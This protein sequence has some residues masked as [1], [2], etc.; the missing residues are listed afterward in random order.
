VKKTVVA[1]EPVTPSVEPILQ[2]PKSFDSYVRQIRLFQQRR[3]IPTS[4]IASMIHS[5]LYMVPMSW[6]SEN[7]NRYAKDAQREI[8]KLCTG[9]F[10]FDQIKVL[11]ADSSSQEYLVEKLSKYAKRVQ[12]DLLVVLSSNRAGLP[13]WLLGSFSETVALTADLPVLVFKPHTKESDFSNKVRILV[14]FDVAATYSKKEISWLIDLAKNTNAHVD[15]VYAKPNQSRIF[16]SL[17][18]PKKQKDAGLNLDV[19]TSDFRKEG[20]SAS[21]KVLKESDSVAESIVEYA[22][23]RQSWMIVTISTQR[24]WA[25]RLLLGSTARK[26]L[27]LT[28]RPFLS[29]RLPKD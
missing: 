10:D 24:Q 17:L 14:A 5:S 6:Y 12:G 19:I 18:L 26:I 2:R 3:L 23:Q 8:K 22:D 11:Q 9:L 20:V 1:I 27:T 29:L 15:L 21:V 13:Y 25:R 28:K 16:D 7:K 4:T